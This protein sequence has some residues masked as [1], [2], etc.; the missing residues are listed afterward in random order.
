MHLGKISSHIYSELETLVKPGSIA[1][2]P[3]WRT[4]FKGWLPLGRNCDVQFLSADIGWL[5]I[6]D[7]YESDDHQNTKMLTTIFQTA[8]GGNTWNKLS[9]VNWSGNFSF[10]SSNEGWGLAINDREQALVVTQDGGRS[11]DI[12]ETKITNE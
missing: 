5:F 8:D 1:E 7:F 2:L 4:D 9:Q 3:T 11:W 12:L 6:Q 10:I